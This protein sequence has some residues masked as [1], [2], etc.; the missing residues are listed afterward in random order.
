LRQEASVLKL[1]WTGSPTSAAAS[2]RG[3]KRISGTILRPPLQRF[4]LRQ[5]WCLTSSTVGLRSLMP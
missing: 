2:I 1:A 3:S 4:P 5:F